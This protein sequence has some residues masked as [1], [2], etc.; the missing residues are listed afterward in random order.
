MHC[1]LG[2]SNRVNIISPTHAS[3][4]H[5]KLVFDSH[6]AEALELQPPINPCRWRNN[7]KLSDVS[8]F[9]F[10]DVSFS[11]MMQCQCNIFA[12]LVITRT[13]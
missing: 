13:V 1:L 11:V 4:C 12:V 2:V 7:L 3:V 10:S 5:W 8:S 9:S 6:Q